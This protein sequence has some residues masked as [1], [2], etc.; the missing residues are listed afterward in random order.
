MGFIKRHWKLFAIVAA[1]LAATYALHFPSMRNVIDLV[2]GIAWPA[3]ALIIVLLFRPQIRELFNRVKK[4]SRDGAEFDGP[5]QQFSSKDDPALPTPTNIHSSPT[6]IGGNQNPDTKPPPESVI[7]PSFRSI[8]EQQLSRIK[9]RLAALQNVFSGSEADLATASAAEL[10][11][12][13]QLERAS[14]TIFRSQ[15]DAL[16]GLKWKP[17]KKDDFRPYYE[18]AK[19]ES[20]DVYQNYGFDQWYA[21]LV[22][23]GLIEGV[24]DAVHVTPAGEAIQMY[25]AQLNYVPHVA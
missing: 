3:T 14:R 18:R 17:V 9:D 15:L 12:A 7:A 2:I 4:L 11:A 20:P 23:S 5:Q 24:D 19:L 22:Q 25:M 21:F 8:Y 1:V 13:L 6:I 10:A 16:A